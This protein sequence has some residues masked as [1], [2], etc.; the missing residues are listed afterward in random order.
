MAHYL[1]D[2]VFH[3]DGLDV[4]IFDINETNFSNLPY[5]QQ[6]QYGHEKNT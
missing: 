3:S 6:H 1:F 5:C 4:V 2:V